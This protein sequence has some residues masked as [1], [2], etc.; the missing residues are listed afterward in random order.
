MSDTVAVVESFCSE[1]CCHVVSESVA[2]VVSE[3]TAALCHTVD[4]D[5]SLLNA[6]PLF[7]SSLPH[8]PFLQSPFPFSPIPR[9]HLGSHA[10][11]LL[12]VLMLSFLFTT[13]SGSHASLLSRESESIRSFGQSSANQQPKFRRKKTQ[14]GRLVSSLDR[15]WII[16]LISF[17][18]NCATIT[19]QLRPVITS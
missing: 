4:V 7:L 14:A 8:P 3:S 5:C 19:S 18:D 9:P 2:A 13:H 12:I 6:A 15:P 17:C 11:S 16:S 10:S 1:S